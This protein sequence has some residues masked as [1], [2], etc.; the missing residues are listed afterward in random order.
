MFP[1]SDM[2]KSFV[3]VGSL[4]VIDAEGKTHV[5]AGGP[6]PE[7]TMRLTDPTLYRKLFFNPEL[8][9]G[10][11]YMDGRMS[12]PGS[13]LRA[14]LT[15][16]SVNRLSLGNQPMQK[17]LRRISRGL[18]RFQQANPVGKAQQNVAHHYDLGNAF[19]KL[20]LDTEMF[21][22]CAYFRDEQE[23]LEQAQRNKCRLIAAKLNLKPGQ[24][25]L[26]I[27]CGWGGLARYL[28]QIADVQVTGV[29][30]SKEQHAL[31]VDSMKVCRTR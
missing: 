30:L 7:A 9:A 20:F 25:V 31:A 17:V 28:A 1:L 2:L 27:G 11:A 23:T 26:D 22:S 24:R 15:L 6:G 10:E 29:T 19:Y 18:K 12:F 3:K 8:H 13:N 21:Y 14:F 4:T 5:F 16:F